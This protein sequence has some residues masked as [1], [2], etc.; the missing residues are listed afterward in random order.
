MGVL[1]AMRERDIERAG[2]RAD[3][4]GRHRDRGFGDARRRLRFRGQ[5]GVCRRLQASIGNALKV[6]ARSRAGLRTSSAARR[7]RSTFRDMITNSADMDAVIRLARSAG[8]QHPDPDRGRIRRRQG[9]GGA[10]H[11]GLRR[12]QV[13]KPFVT[14]NCGAIPTISSNR[15]CSATRRARSPAP[16]S[17][18]SAS[19]SRPWR[20]AVPRRGRRPAAR[21]AGQAAAR[22]PGRRGRS[23]RRQDARSGRHPHHLGDQPQPAA[24]RSRTASSARICSTASTSSRSR[25]AAA[26]APRGHPRSRAGLPGALRR[27]GRQEAARHRLPRPW[28]DQRL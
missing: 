7:P 26:R 27:R 8:I 15:S 3:R 28:A 2:H 1:A 6:E 4:A 14:V 25:A 13:R 23:G 10:R 11:P 5:A 24:S 9:G 22:D 16:P 20:H 12:P 17:A 18:T 19:S 21:R